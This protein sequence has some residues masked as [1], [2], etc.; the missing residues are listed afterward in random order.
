[1]HTCTQLSSRVSARIMLDK[2]YA[3]DEA[4]LRIAQKLTE[5][6]FSKENP[7]V[8]L[9]QASLDDVESLY[10]AFQAAH[11]TFTPTD[12]WKIVAMSRVRDTEEDKSVSLH[13]AARLHEAQ[14][15]RNIFNALGRTLNDQEA[16]GRITLERVIL[17]ALPHPQ[18][19]PLAYHFASRA[20][21]IAQLA[22]LAGQGQPGF[23][24][25]TNRASYLYIGVYLDSFFSES[26]LTVDG[27]HLIGPQKQSDGSFLFRQVAYSPYHTLPM[28]YATTDL[29]PLVEVLICHA[30]AGTHLLCGQPLTS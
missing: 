1:M 22:R 8:E 12:Y 6:Y 28:I 23:E 10:Q 25:V 18:G 15:Y 4:W 3:S 29:G 11:A 5:N 20:N 26:Y 17:S 19:Y 24:K 2:D 16:A 27:R 9:V 14:R 30:P 13:Q 21:G 7:Y